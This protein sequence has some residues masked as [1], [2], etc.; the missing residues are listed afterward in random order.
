MYG[1]HGRLLHVDL[2]S[3]NYA[4]H[5]IVES[6]LRW[7]LGGT[8]LGA[9]L[10]YQFA[11]AG[12]DPFHPQNPLIFC[13]APLVGTGLTTTAKYAIVTKSPLTG[14]I[15]DSLSSSFFALELKKCGIDALVVIG[16]APSWIYLWIKDEK[17]ELRDAATL[18]GNSASMPHFFNSS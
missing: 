10:L 6:R 1:F 3:G 9:A 7:F 4:F 17:V 18:I 13:S 11:P 5:D 15:G 14:F 12:V 16:R 8:G 2:A